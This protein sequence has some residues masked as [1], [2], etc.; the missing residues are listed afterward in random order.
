M[1]DEASEE[2]QKRTF[3]LKL[4]FVFPGKYQQ[5]LELVF[6]VSVNRVL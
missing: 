1:I 4:L 3:V 5:E 2:N 6:P